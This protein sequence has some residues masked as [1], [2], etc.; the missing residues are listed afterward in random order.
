VS[1]QLIEEVTVGN[2][3]LRLIHEELPI[4]K[5]DLDENNPR[6]R[7]RLMASLNGKPLQEAIRSMH[8]FPGL[9]KD[10]EGNGGLREK[11]IAQRNGNGKFKVIEGNCRLTALEDLHRKM[12]GDSRWKK[13][14]ARILP[15]DAD[16]KQIA[17]LLSDFHVAGK[18]EWRAHEKAGQ[19]YHMVTK[20]TMDQG[21]VATYLRTSK[22]TVNRWLA[23]YRFMVEKFLKAYPDKGEGTWS[24]FEEFFK[25]SD[26][27]N[28][29]KANPEFGDDFCRWIGEGRLPQPVLVRQLPDV[30][31]NP[32]ARKKLEKGGTFA[33]AM[34]IVETSDPEQGSDFF[35][36]LAKMRESCSNAAQVKEILRIRSDKNARVKVL[37]TYKALVDFMKLADV[38]IPKD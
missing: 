14:P 13:V 7:Y 22:A 33:E 37:D 32:E 25:K 19:V 23:A 34:K 15:E 18:I 36:M 10:I 20:L 21:E 9:K 35:K 26:L 3:A 8:E 16:P 6:I 31:K 29:L 12:P 5:L 1:D 17:I 2:K 4:E 27:V 11:I 38:E 28:E 30:L 24:Y